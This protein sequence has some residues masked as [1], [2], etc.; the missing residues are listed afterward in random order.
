MFINNSLR[1]IFIQYFILSAG[2]SLD[3]ETSNISYYRLRNMINEN[4]K[5]RKL[6][7]G[8]LNKNNTW[9][10]A[11]LFN[12][13]NREV[14]FFEFM[15]DPDNKILLTK[16]KKKWEE[17]YSYDARQ[18]LWSKNHPHR[19]SFIHWNKD[20]YEYEF[21]RA[22]FEQTPAKIKQI[23]R[24]G[25]ERTVIGIDDFHLTSVLGK[26]RLIAVIRDDIK[27]KYIPVL[28]Q[29]IYGNNE[30]RIN[31]LNPKEIFVSSDNNN[32]NNPVLITTK[33]E[34]TKTDI[35]Y[36]RSVQLMHDTNN[37]MIYSDNLAK[38]LYQSNPSFSA[39]GQYISFVENSRESSE[40]SKYPVMNLFICETPEFDSTSQQYIQGDCFFIDDNVITEERLG[41]ASGVVENYSWHPNDDILFYAKEDGSRS[42]SRIW[43]YDPHTG[44]KKPLDTG[45][46]NNHSISFSQDGEFIIFNA[47]TYKSNTNKHYSNCPSDL[48]SKNNDCCGIPSSVICVAELFINK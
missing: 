19:F 11:E 38:D 16:K 28:G 41:I 45:M 30:L 29:D 1:L 21:Y 25:T 17:N 3:I 44:I 10:S 15:G 46:K 9:L 36:F 33:N 7:R 26:D 12:E 23:I 5:G 4:Y 14:Y 18:L 24:L 48:T 20:K 34:D 32:F 13:N 47:F 31:Y 35:Y 6:H 22:K 40:K 27:R 2:L 43:Y 42:F 37:V 8:M 39:S